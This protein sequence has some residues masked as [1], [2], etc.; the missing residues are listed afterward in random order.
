MCIRDRRSWAARGFS[1][2][3]FPEDPRATNEHSGFLGEL[4][5]QL[6]SRQSWKLSIG[7]VRV[8][9]H[10]DDVRRRVRRRTTTYN[11]AAR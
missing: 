1:E 6:S 7:P 9:I 4:L 2:R 11:D 5:R 3:R 8:W 10:N